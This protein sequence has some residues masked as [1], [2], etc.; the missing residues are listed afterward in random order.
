MAGGEGDDVFY[1]IGGGRDLLDCGPG[2]DVV[3]VDRRDRLR[4]CESIHR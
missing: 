3:Y 1:A 2:R 4:G